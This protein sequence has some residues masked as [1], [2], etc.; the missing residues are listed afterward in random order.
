MKTITVRANEI[1]QPVYAGAGSRITLT[2][3]GYVEWAGVEKLQDALNGATWQTWPAGSTAGYRDTDRGMAIRVVGTGDCTV[4]VEEGKADR[5]NE[6]AY[7]QGVGDNAT[8]VTNT[9]TGGIAISAGTDSP[10]DIVPAARFWLP[11]FRGSAGSAI[12]KTYQGDAA[13]QGLGSATQTRGYFTSKSGTFGTSGTGLYYEIDAV[14]GNF[15]LDTHSAIFHCT[16]NMAAP[17]STQYPV[18]T[19]YNSSSPGILIAATAAGELKPYLRIGSGGTQN[20]MNNIPGMCDG[21][22]HDI[23][24][25]FDRNERKC[26]VFADGVLFETKALAGTGTTDSGAGMRFGG[27]AGGGTCDAKFA[28]AHMYVFAADAADL[29]VNAIVDKLVLQRQ[30]LRRSDV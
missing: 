22:D 15:E 3:S 28:N 21:T 10:S 5:A 6:N 30:P 1:S 16:I 29:D 12:D 17:G 18:S 2:G 26:Y 27:Y 13:K 23:T 4:T 20:A 25:V 14:R 9:L 11:W 8:V 24:L 7:W 19:Q